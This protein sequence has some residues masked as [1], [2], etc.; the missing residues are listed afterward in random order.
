MFI[1][2]PSMS[3]DLKASIYDWQKS[4]IQLLELRLICELKY[5]VQPST[6]A[7]ELPGLFS[8]PFRLTQ[9]SCQNG[10]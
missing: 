7:T 5:F 10:E 6:M 1:F 2:V 4:T 3:K 8:A 9:G